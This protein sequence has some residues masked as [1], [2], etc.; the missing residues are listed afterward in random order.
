MYWLTDETNGKGNDNNVIWVMSK[1][2]WVYGAFMDWR[3]ALDLL[4]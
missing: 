2:E 3:T 1:N 4:L